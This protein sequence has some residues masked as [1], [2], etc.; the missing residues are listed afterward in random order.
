[1]VSTLY[2]YRVRLR[3]ETT[4]VAH[5]FGPDTT[6]ERYHFLFFNPAKK[7]PAPRKNFAKRMERGLA[8]GRR[9]PDPFPDKKFSDRWIDLAGVREAA[10]DPPRPLVQAPCE[11]FS[12]KRPSDLPKTKDDSLVPSER[13]GDV[14]FHRARLPSERRSFP[15]RGEGM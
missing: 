10:L 11:V 13:K 15:S 1:M 8:G 2:I 5:H 3:P 7:D 6:Q 12:K 9:H 14:P 4:H